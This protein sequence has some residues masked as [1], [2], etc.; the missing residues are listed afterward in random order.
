MT[1]LLHADRPR[2]YVAD[3]NAR[4]IPA[5]D[6][7]SILSCFSKLHAGALVT[8]RVNARDAVK[9]QPLRELSVDRSDILVRTGRATDPFPQGFRVPRVADVRI[10][11]TGEGA[12]AAVTMTA[13]DGTRTEVRFRSPMRDDVLD[14]LVE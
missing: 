14:P 5:A 7:P 10:E 13:I 1:G 3:M 8:V 6:R 4:I 11:E 12:D 9:D 2:A